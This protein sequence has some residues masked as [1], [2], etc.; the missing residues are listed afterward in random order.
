MIILSGK[1]KKSFIILSII[2]SLSCLIFALNNII[3]SADDSIYSV[4]TNITIFTCVLIISWLCLFGLLY[5]TVKSLLLRYR[6]QTNR[7]MHYI[8]IVVIVFYL[9][10]YFPFHIFILPVSLWIILDFLG[11]IFPWILIASLSNRF[12]K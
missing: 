8:S 9:V 11:M 12:C 7:L 6:Q 3:F 10:L 5:I 4:Y 1:D 2:F